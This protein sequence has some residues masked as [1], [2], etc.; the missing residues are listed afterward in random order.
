M[1]EYGFD[2][3]DIRS[4]LDVSWCPRSR[5]TEADTENYVYLLQDIQEYSQTSN[6]GWGLS[7]TASTSYWYVRWFDIGNMT[8]YVDWVNLM[9]YDLYV[10]KST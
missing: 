6:L 5:G 2:G 7:F 4:R 10:L 8:L 1:R 3:V 9:T